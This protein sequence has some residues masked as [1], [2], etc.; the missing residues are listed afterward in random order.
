MLNIHIICNA[1]IWAGTKESSY[2]GK[3]IF[4]TA[5]AILDVK[6]GCLGMSV[7]HGEMRKRDL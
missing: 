4:S 5:G 7:K 1:K 2:L 6:K 3:T